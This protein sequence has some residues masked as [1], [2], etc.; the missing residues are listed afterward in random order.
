ME[1]LEW[2]GFFLFRKVATKLK[3]ELSNMKTKP[4]IYLNSLQ[5]GQNKFIVELLIK[6]ILKL[7]IPWAWT[8]NSSVDRS[9]ALFMTDPD[10]IF[11]MPY[12]SL[13]PTKRVIP[14]HHW[15]W[16]KPLQ[17]KTKQNKTSE[18]QIMKHSVHLDKVIC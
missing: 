14:E 15:V 5:I 11:G 3:L 9:F 1:A 6:Q 17:N 18:Q 8:I 16:L 4:L 2:K 10:S 7:F 12:G 13:S